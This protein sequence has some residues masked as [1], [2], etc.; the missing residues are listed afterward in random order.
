MELFFRD[1]V[2]L[3]CPHCAYP[4]SVEV[5]AARRVACQT[6]DA[7]VRCNVC[8]L[9]VANAAPVPC[10]QHELERRTVL[11]C[12]FCGAHKP[13]VASFCAFCKRWQNA[14]SGRELDSEESTL[15]QRIRWHTC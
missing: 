15:S 2:Y 9:N 5:E 8:T 11:Y 12:V 6:P 7:I 1:G 3:V 13:A 14:N 4:L 10:T